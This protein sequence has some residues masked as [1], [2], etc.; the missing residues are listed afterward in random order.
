MHNMIQIIKQAAMEAV[1]A[2]NPTRV[3]FGTVLSTSPLS[4]KIDQKFTL[5]QDFLILTKNVMDYTVEMT[6]EHSTEEA[7][8]HLHEYKGRK[9]FTVH[10]GLKVGEKVILLQIQGGQKYIVL[11]KVGG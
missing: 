2:S 9:E 4:V 11:D 10:N 8:G 6:V 5:T 7:A 1:D 3:F